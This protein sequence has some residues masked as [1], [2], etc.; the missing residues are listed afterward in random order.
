M[1]GPASRSFL[2]SR[3]IG[4]LIIAAGL[5]VNRYSVAWAVTTDGLIESSRNT[6]LILAA[7]AVCIAIGVLAVLG[8]VR[9]LDRAWIRIPVAIAALCAIPVASYGM[10]RVSGVIVTAREQALSDAFSHSTQSEMIHSRVA[11]RLRGL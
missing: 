11:M 7:Q 1:S 5:F 3:R 6:M 4:W 2:D 9:L 10:L 8:K